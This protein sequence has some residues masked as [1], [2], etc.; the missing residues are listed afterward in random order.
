MDAT[1]GKRM[2]SETNQTP[3]QKGYTN[4]RKEDSEV[5]RLS[6][7]IVRAKVGKN[8]TAVKV[9]SIDRK[10]NGTLTFLCENIK[11]GK[12]M[13]VSD[14]GRFI[15]AVKTEKKSTG[16]KPPRVKED[17]TMSALNAAFKVLSEEGRAMSVKEIYET[18]VE[19]GYCNLAGATPA[20]TIYGI[21]HNEIKNRGSESRFYKAGRGLFAVQ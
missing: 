10:V 1:L 12:P 9:V 19:R 2:P 14:A 4:E 17:G 21:I 6:V 16:E 11:T 8:T 13:T 20:L 18:A 15:K 7:F 5:R 3:Y